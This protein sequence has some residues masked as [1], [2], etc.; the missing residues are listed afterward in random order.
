MKA[1]AVMPHRRGLTLLSAAVL[2]SCIL[3]W[4]TTAVAQ[5]GSGAELTGSA[6]LAADIG[7]R[8]VADGVRTTLEFAEAGR[9]GGSAGCN[10]YFGPV[11]IEGDAIAVGNLAA[12]RMMCPPAL[13]DQEQ[14]F[15]QA[16]LEARRF[17]LEG[18]GEKLLVYGDD[19]EP[20]IQFT[21]IVEK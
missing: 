19:A 21:R 14:R 4:T 17:E 15:M 13:M 8:G 18:D 12:T 11:S 6:W 10:R 16:L 2:M 7:G 1:R 9:V 5:S 3:L 20:L